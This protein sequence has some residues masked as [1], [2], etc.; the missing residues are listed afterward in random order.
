MGG[1]TRI[2]EG[3]Q[4]WRSRGKT[5]LSATEEN[6]T[7]NSASENQWV[8]E[9]QGIY[10][11]DYVPGHQGGSLNNGIEVKLNIFFDGTQNNKTNTDARKAKSKDYHK[12][13]NKKDD[14][15]ENE[16]TNIARGYDA[17]DPAV[18]YQEKIYIEGIGTENLESDDV[19]PDVLF[20]MGSRGI[21]AK[22]T[23]A[24]IQAAK[25]LYLK[26]PKKD[27]D[28][29]YVNVYGFSRGAAAARHFLHVA[30]SPPEYAFDPHIS[31][32]LQE[33]GYALP[34]EGSAGKK[35]K[36]KRKDPLVRNHGYF[37]A[38]LLEEKLSVKKIQFHFTG[39][40]DTVSSHGPYHGNDVEDLKLN[41]VKKS[42]MVVQFSSDDEYRENFDLTNIDSAGISGLEFTLP[43][44]HS[45]IG[46]SYLE[47]SSELSVIAYQSRGLIDKDISKEGEYEKFREILIQEG[48]Y[49]PKEITL[50]TFY[51]S[52]LYKDSPKIKNLVRYRGLVG[53]RSLSN[54]YDR[55]PLRLMF[56]HSS[57]FGV[58]Y[59]EKIKKKYEEFK[60]PFIQEVYNQLIDYVNACATIRNQCIKGKKTG[61]EYLKQVKKISYLNYIKK[62]T[63]KKLRNRYLHWSAKADQLG[64][65]PRVSG[66]LASKDRKREIHNG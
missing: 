31:P 5:E 56:H 16:Y 39:L 14:S 28:I 64:L 29:L 9:Q 23:K 50:R 43:G 11:K 15:Y 37:G 10:E 42:H 3:D 1:I 58:V 13:S 51:F 45:D 8:G 4:I 12:R 49:Q 18:L 22:V 40:Y 54:A 52:D 53:I 61:K 32:Q 35:I 59:S 17:V 33:E 66:A 57:Q 19:M 55:I 21:T 38:C 24:C 62:D 65:E 46:G 27:I 60:D 36:V 30:G 48:W 20:G 26:Y 47:Q 63:L 34:P 44:V 7:F 2:T 25:Q 41:A 6:C